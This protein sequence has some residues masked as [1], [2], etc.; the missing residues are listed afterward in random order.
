MTSENVFIRYLPLLLLAVLWEIAPRPFRRSERTAAA[1]CGRQR[2]VV[3][4]A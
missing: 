4:A 3:V 1:K 2:L